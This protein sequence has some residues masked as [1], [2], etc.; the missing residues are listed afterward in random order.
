MKESLLVK[1]I[2]ATGR[3]NFSHHNERTERRGEK[4]EKKRE[5]GKSK[6]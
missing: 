1:Q 2:P 6:E 4:K 5:K 3:E